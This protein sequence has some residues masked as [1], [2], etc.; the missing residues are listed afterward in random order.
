MEAQTS[1]HQENPCIEVGQVLGLFLLKKWKVGII[2]LT[3][4]IIS[5]ATPVA[6]SSTTPVVTPNIFSSGYDPLPPLAILIRIEIYQL[7]C[8]LH[9]SCC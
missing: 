9:V 7:D 4:S 6:T 1:T 2:Y 5:S 3:T 8:G